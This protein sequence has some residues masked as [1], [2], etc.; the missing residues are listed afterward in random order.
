MLVTIG[1]YDLASLNRVMALVLFATGHYSCAVNF[2]NLLV[3]YDC[4]RSKRIKRDVAAKLAFYTK[5]RSKMDDY[6]RN[7]FRPSYKA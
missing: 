3:T 1:R 4:I 6:S 5:N 7:T 2:L